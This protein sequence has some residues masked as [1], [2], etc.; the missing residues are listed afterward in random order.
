MFMSVPSWRTLENGVSFNG[1][2]VHV[3]HGIMP[4]WHTSLFDLSIFGL[5]RK[6]RQAADQ[7][8]AAQMLIMAR[9]ALKQLGMPIS[10]KATVAYEVMSCD[11]TDPSM[12]FHAVVVPAF[13][14]Y[15]QVRCA[16]EILT[17]P[18]DHAL[19]QE[20]GFS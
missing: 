8:F 20:D 1:W 3:F 13:L 14:Y 7:T 17:E 18:A 11:L 9:S 4:S 6:R 10:L 12:D 15:S 16:R 5:N 2:C 19:R